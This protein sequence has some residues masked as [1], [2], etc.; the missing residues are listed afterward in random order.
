MKRKI[1]LGICLSALVLVIAP[2]ISAQTYAQIKH[3]YET[4]IQEQF[5][6]ITTAQFTDLEQKDEPK[7]E[8]LIS[9]MTN[10]KETMDTNDESSFLTSGFIINTI[11][12]L[13][14][15]LIGTIFGMIFGPI[16]AMVALIL[17][18]PALLLSKIISLILGNEV[19]LNN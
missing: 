8:T 4:T 1:L 12:S 2:T 14:F 15:S 9:I 3:A 6:D 17:A 19:I 5:P 10:L 18:S 16:L 11:I 13:F 7:Q